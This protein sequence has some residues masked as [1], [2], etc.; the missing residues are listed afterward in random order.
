MA[1]SEI[2]K[3]CFKCFGTGVYVENRIDG[4]VDIDPCPV[5]N[6]EKYLDYCYLDLAKFKQAFDALEAKLDQ[7][8]A[9][10]SA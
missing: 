4:D 9:A 7:I 1:K 5:C 8:I 2:Q 3:I 6:G 10:L